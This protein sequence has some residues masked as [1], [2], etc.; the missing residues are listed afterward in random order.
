M[1]ANLSKPPQVRTMAAALPLLA[2]M[3]L[4]P[5]A[6]VAAEPAEPTADADAKVDAEVADE[7]YL[8]LTR[9]EDGSGGLETANATFVR[10]TDG[11]RVDLLSV[12]HIA[13]EDY[14][15]KF[16]EAFTGYDSVLFELVGDPGD[17]RQHLQA[18][19][20]R[21]GLS[22]SGLQGGLGRA[23][24]LAFQMDGVDYSAENLVHADM[25]AARFRERQRE[26]GEGFLQLYLK[27]V[28][29]SMSNPRA[30]QTSFGLLDLAEAVISEDRPNRLKWLMAGE[31]GNAEDILGLLE[32]EEGSVII[33]ERNVV[34][35][36]V[37]DQRI[38]DGDRKLAIFYGAGHMADFEERL[39][40]LG[41]ELVGKEWWTAWKLA[42]PVVRERINPADEQP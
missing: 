22:L 1:L 6:A 40:A 35:M 2:A 37:L 21:G 24:D 39:V 4:M 27:A 28:R 11:V 19:D 42:A 17:L 13:D 14:Y 33:A 25:S 26:R 23:L 16:N 15:A 9:N 38:A 36:D 34:A 8:R 12:V 18:G 29:A 3:L 10:A 5:G 30:A 32:G 31:M 7:A 41:F 20:S